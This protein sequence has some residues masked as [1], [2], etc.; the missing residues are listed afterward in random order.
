MFFV[1]VCCKPC[2][3]SLDF[4]SCC[5]LSSSNQDCRWHRVTCFLCASSSVVV[6]FTEMQKATQRKCT[7]LIFKLHI[8]FMQWQ[9]LSDS[10]LGRKFTTGLLLYS[11]N[12]QHIS[13]IYIHVCFIRSFLRLPRV[14]A[15]H[16]N[17]KNCDLDR[18]HS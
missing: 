18:C 14:S 13:R 4:C 17:Q 16:G 6:I 15:K 5:W 11:V 7:V 9:D 12:S 2:D 10:R 8:N 3:V 1:P